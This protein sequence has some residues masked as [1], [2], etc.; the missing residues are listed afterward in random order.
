MELTFSQVEG[1]VDQAIG[2]EHRLVRLLDLADCL[3][4]ADLELVLGFNA[5]TDAATK[6][7]ERRWVDKQEVS[8]DRVFVDLLGAIAVDLDDRD[9]A[10]LLDAFKLFV[11][12][13]ILVAVLL[14]SRLNKLASC[15]HLSK[16]CFRYEVEVFLLLLDLFD[17]PCCIGFLALKQVAVLLQDVAD[18]SVFTNTRWAHHNKR[19]LLLRLLVERVEVL[20]CKHEDVVL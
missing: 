13:S 5:L 4:D 19:L 7:G 17:T 15:F 9:L 3:L 10:R 2:E 16:L 1:V 14:L 12:G 11:R 6:L 18:Q 8:F 20:L